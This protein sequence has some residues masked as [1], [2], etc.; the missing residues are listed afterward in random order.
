MI[1]G[2]KEKD[3]KT[4][5]NARNIYFLNEHSVLYAMQCLN[6]TK[7]ETECY[8]I[9]DSLYYIMELLAV[10]SQ[11]RKVSLVLGSEACFPKEVSGDRIKFEM[12]I[13][14]LLDY[15][16]EHSSESEIKLSAKLKNPDAMG[17]LLSFEIIAS[18]NE[19]I[20]AKSLEKI[21]ACKDKKYTLDLSNCKAI[22]NKLKGNAEFI[23]NDE[24]NSLKVYIELPF[25]NR[26]SSKELMPIPRLNIYETEKMNE[27]T[28]RW[29]PKPVVV[30]EIKQPDLVKLISSPSLKQSDRQIFKSDVGKRISKLS[31]SED[32]VKKGVMARL[33]NEPVAETPQPVNLY[34]LG[35]GGNTTVAI[36]RN[37]LADPDNS[38]DMPVV[39]NDLSHKSESIKKSAFVGENEPSANEEE[40]K[41]EKKTDRK[42]ES[43][44]IVAP[45]YI[46]LENSG[47]ARF[48]EDKMES[49]KSG[50]KNVD[51]SL[52][53][54]DYEYTKRV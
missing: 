22:I 4:L 42:E 14:G 29:L 10:K 45:F 34:P 38:P 19:E 53:E 9:I 6:D 26:D 2:K 7:L 30:H 16:I 48:E 37:K 39:L 23:D 40:K 13:T 43:K 51:D 25:A 5:L 47:S 20:N 1:K 18:K 50:E 27:Y 24:S 12:L 49:A 33:K 52:E 46:D 54:P 44:L 3:S 36:G 31:P 17:F 41:S 32:L 11:S 8:N 28:V 21:Y 15:L 35:N